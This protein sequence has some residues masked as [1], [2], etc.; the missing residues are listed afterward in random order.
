MLK[1]KLRSN[2]VFWLWGSTTLILIIL[3]INQLLI[4]KSQMESD[5]KENAINLAR[6]YGK[7]LDA[8]FG[9]AAMIP[10]ME[11]IY[12]ESGFNWENKEAIKKYLKQTVETNPSIYG[13]AIA[14]RIDP[15]VGGRAPFSPYYYRERG[16]LEYKD[17]GHNDYRY[18]EREWF[19]QPQ[20]L[21]KALWTDAYYDTGGGNAL[22]ITYAHPFY[23]GKEFAGVA[24]VDVSLQTIVDD[25]NQLK[26]HETGYGFMVNPEG[27][28]LAFPD[29][30]KMANGN[31]KE[32]SPS[33]ADKMDS[34]SSLPSGS[35]LFVEGPDPLRKESSWMILRPI[36]QEQTM[37]GAVVFVYPEKEVLNSLI[38]LQAKTFFVGV[39]GLLILLI[40]IIVVSNSISRPIVGL[41]K[42][43]DQ[44]AK[45]DLQ[46]RIDVTANNLEVL[47]LQNGFNKML[48]DLQLYIKNLRETTALNERIESELT[49]AHQIQASMLP[50][51]FPPFPHR[52][53]IDIFALMDP[54]KEVG[55]DFYDFFLVDKNKLC[56]LIGDVSGKGVPAAL[57]MMINKVLLKNEGMSGNSPAQ[58][59]SKVN[60]IIS[61]DNEELMFVTIFCVVLDLVTGEVCFANAGHNPP[62]MGS[63]E[64]G[65]EYLKPDHNFV[66][67]VKADVNFTLNKTAMRR[68]D[69]FFLY[70]DGV[71]EA[72]NKE[73]KLFSEPRLQQ[74]LNAAKDQGAAGLIQK[75]RKDINE[76]AQGAEQSDDI[77]ML[78]V[79]YYGQN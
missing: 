78:A 22:M 61:K 35:W 13:S 65:F 64:S 43:V 56:F 58:I 37:V 9:P 71:T 75:I 23:R 63:L 46:H 69:T 31:I 10:T 36:R 19:K 16:Q 1:F 3:L 60:N 77:T 38:V 42:G 39:T 50:R 53:D 18:W 28:F 17:L 41:S 7:R 55:G 8:F 66:L 48:E 27:N 14:L 44:A 52:N 40:V 2:M 54:A 68:G 15:T 12:M 76:F 32:L 62:L 11:A 5:L 49:L 74:C 4:N 24:T 59:L 45:G 6:Y 30:D 20:T 67:G 25:I 29:K 51:V 26:V 70:T 57:F 72:L 21:G 33:F 47:T 34:L 73:S 79:K